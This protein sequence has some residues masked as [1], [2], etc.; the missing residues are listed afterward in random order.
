MTRGRKERRGGNGRGKAGETIVETLVAVL[1]IGL[2]AALFLTMVG[3][4]GKIFRRAEDG[5]DELYEKISEA[6]VQETAYPGGGGTIT[7]RGEGSLIPDTFTVDWYG[8]DYVRSY[9]HAR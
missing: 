1:M 2:S 9:N 5:Y 6:D 7:V 8:N 3:A 4:A